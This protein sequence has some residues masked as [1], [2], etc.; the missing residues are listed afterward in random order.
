M[1]R[2]LT[3][4]MILLVVFLAGL[5]ALVL[6][7]NPNDFRDYMA[8]QVEA[9]S[10]YQ[11]KLD[12]PLRWH[13]WPQLSI[14]S[15]RMNLTAPGASVPLVSADN[16]RL[17]VEL[18]PLLSHQLQV[19]QVMLKGAVVQL[20]PQSE[21]RHPQGAP[22]GPKG[23]VTPDEGEHGWSF[24]IAR[25]KVADSLLVFQHEDDEQVTVRNLNLQMS[26]DDKHQAQV[27]LSARVNRD[28]RDLTFSLAAHLDTADYPQRLLAS[29]TQFDWQLQGA[30]LPRQGIAGKMT[31]Q[32]QW[33]EMSK[34]L[35]F[36]QLNLTANDSQLAGQGSVALADAPAWTL[37]L[38][39]DRLNLEN[40]IAP[41]AV[42]STEARQ[43]GQ[44]SQPATPR[45]AL[46]RPVIARDDDEAQ[47]ASLRGFTAQASVQARS[48]RWRGLEFSN[49]AAQMTNEA[50]LLTLSRLEGQLGDGKLSL[51]GVLD[52]RDDEPAAAFKVQAEN[53][54]VGS[55]LTAFHYPIALTGKLSLN[56]EFNGDSIDAEAFRQ[57]WEGKASV[58]M[59]NTRLEGMNFQQLIQQAVARSNG[60]VKA[61]QNYDNA[62]TLE[63]FSAAATLDHGELTLGEMQG[64]S[65]LLSLDGEG[66]LDLVRE[67]CDTRFNV[68]V[69]GG[70]EGDDKL[71]AW[72]KETPVP[73]R[74]YGPWQK[75]N[76]SLQVDDVLRKHLQEEAKRRLNDWADRHKESRNGKELKKLLDKL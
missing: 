41:D 26:Q 3:A 37:D 11:L 27:E 63:Q 12:G 66:S 5:S 23:S 1:R 35:S 75:L 14:L 51:P 25:L 50:G 16:M 2:L 30:D 39:S 54:E 18:L 21:A 7:V 38:H 22:V 4:L 53:V 40:L 45:A 65:S 70:W 71:V 58:M 29:I 24:D 62:T 28:Q 32:A 31:V 44:Q 20:T 8:R 43:Q 49:V 42:T 64:R 52:A 13:V 9:R 10:G 61:Q 73:L 57:R 6:L 59:T 74:V 19:R 56:G 60:G 33:Q 36:S 47:Y 67:Q 15:G 46:P 55:I 72:L 17:D 69:N 34:T 48:V 76:Y 68:L